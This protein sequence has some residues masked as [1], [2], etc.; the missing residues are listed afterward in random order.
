MKVLRIK[1]EIDLRELEKYGY[2]ENESYPNYVY[3]TRTKR[4]NYC[5]I[6]VDKNTRVI[7][8]TIVGVEHYTLTGNQIEQYAKSI[9]EAGMVEEVEE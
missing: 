1:D 5:F 9:F 8:G 6:M 4:N 3:E 7:S 2:E